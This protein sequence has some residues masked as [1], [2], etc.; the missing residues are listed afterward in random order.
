MASQFAP[1]VRAVHG[2]STYELQLE[3]AAGGGPVMPPRPPGCGGRE[4]PAAQLPDAVVRE[5]PD[6][7]AV[8]EAFPGA[9]VELLVREGQ[10][11]SEN[12]D[13]VLSHRLAVVA[14]SGPDRESLIER[15]QQAVG[16][17]ALRPGAGAGPGR[18]LSS[19]LAVPVADRVRLARDQIVAL[20]A[21]E[22]QHLLAVGEHRNRRPALG[23]K[24][25]IR[26]GTSPVLT[27]RCPPSGPSGKQ[28]RSPAA[29][30]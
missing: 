21:A 22:Q 11:L 6:T 7:A 2:V 12:D 28:T 4:L 16:A 5:V 18:R 25:T 1:L 9:L 15:Y 23:R 24:I 8:T 17:A 30:A 10:R 19:T 3:L 27:T 14:L 20:A 29:R 13:D 26:A